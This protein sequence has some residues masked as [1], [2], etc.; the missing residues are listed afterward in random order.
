MMLKEKKWK[1]SE[2]HHSFII[3]YF[4][5]SGLFLTFLRVC[6]AWLFCVHVRPCVISFFVLESV[7]H[8]SYP[9]QNIA[10]VYKGL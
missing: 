6:G 3:P 8:V 1:G 4:F 10:K 5:L 9:P 7:Y 2:R